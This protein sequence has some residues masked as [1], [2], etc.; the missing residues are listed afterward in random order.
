MPETVTYDLGEIDRPGITT[1]RESSRVAPPEPRRGAPPRFCASLTLLLPGA[2][3]LVAGR[4]GAAGLHLS[5]LA[6]VA[7]LGWAVWV[8]LERVA[9]TASVLGASR[10]L[11]LWVLGGLYACVAFCHLGA[12]LGCARPDPETDRGVPPWVAGFASI[13]LPG[14]GQV[15]NGQRQRAALLLAGLW[16]S[17]FSWL[18]VSPL[19]HE[20]LQ[21]L[22]LHLPAELTLLG[23][24]ALRWTLPAV[25]WALAVYD[26]VFFAAT[27]D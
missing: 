13:L 19:L 9:A 4:P 21:R 22:D 15:L 1:R 20:Q 27:R 23:A 3:Q 10:G 11:G 7:S 26:A 5:L 24:P 2:G 8:T 18:L 17:G 14:W 25:I 6:L 12:V 16:L